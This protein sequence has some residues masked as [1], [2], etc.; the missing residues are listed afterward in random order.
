MEKGWVRE[1]KSPCVMP[2]IIVPKKD[3]SWRMC[4]NYH[5]I[6][7]IIVRY[8]HPIPYLDDLLD[9]LHGACIFSKIDMQSGYHHIC[10]R[11]SDEWKT[12]FK[13]KFGLYEW[14][15]MPFRLT[16]VPSMF[17]RLMNHVLRNL[18]GCCT[19]I[20]FDDILVYYECLDDHVRH[21]HQVLQFLKGKSLYEVIYLG[22]F[23]DSQVNYVDKEK[24]KAIKS[25]P[26]F[27]SVSEC[28]KF[29]W[30]LDGKNPKR[31]PSRP[32]RKGHPMPPC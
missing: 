15:V 3:K 11:E 28:A 27:R 22:F 21:V 6:N 2:M 13:T 10:M 7:A 14:L 20:Y 29:P 8:R 1:S 23:V 18:I 9:E 19:V 30:G 24:V 25:W 26:T 16:N 5:L 17:M 4:M 12:A 31:N 32:L